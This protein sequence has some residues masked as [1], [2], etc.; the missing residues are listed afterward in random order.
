MSVLACDCPTCP[1]R[2]VVLESTG[3]GRGQRCRV[4]GWLLRHLDDDAEEEADR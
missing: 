3:D 4:C 2:G 1:D